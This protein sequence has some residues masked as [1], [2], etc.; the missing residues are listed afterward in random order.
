MILLPS[1]I[2]LPRAVAL[3]VLPVHGVSPCINFPPPPS[4]P[5]GNKRERGSERRDSEIDRQ[6][7][8]A[9]A[10]PLRLRGREAP[11]KFGRL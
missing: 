5:S 2:T 7:E 10:K 6:R 11:K 3:G 4:S 8:R 9:Q 1:F